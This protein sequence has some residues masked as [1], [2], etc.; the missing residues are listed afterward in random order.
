MIIGSQL[1]VFNYWFHWLFPNYHFQLLIWLIGFKWSLS[2][3]DVID[4]FPISNFNYWYDW[5]FP[6]IRFNNWCFDWFPIINFNYWCYWLV[7]KTCNQLLI[8]IV[9]KWKIHYCTTLCPMVFNHWIE[10]NQQHKLE[11]I[12]YMFKKVLP[13]SYMYRHDRW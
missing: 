2:I 7:L 6:M 11:M 8:G 10:L 5:L 3:I 4:W 9:L 13:L 12:L 1:L